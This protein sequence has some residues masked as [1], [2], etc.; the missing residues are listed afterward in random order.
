MGTFIYGTP[1]IETNFDDRALTH[2]QIV[3]MAKL[4]HNES[5]AFS[6]AN[7]A[8]K[9]SGRSSVWLSPSIPLFFRFFGSKIPDINREWLQVLQQSADSGS[10][11]IFTSE[12]P[13]AASTNTPEA[14]NRM[15]EPTRTPV[16]AKKRSTLVAV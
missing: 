14:P 1:G 12:P 4:R 9:G 6:W 8:D 2:V 11:L 5:F 7:D 16:P 13:R 10:G 15:Q 3:I